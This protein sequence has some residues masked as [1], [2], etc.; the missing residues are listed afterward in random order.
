[1][2]QA[3]PQVPKIAEKQNIN[4]DHKTEN[5]GNQLEE[6]AEDSKGESEI[7]S[8]GSNDEIE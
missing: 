2:H 8:E 5:F 4:I 1:V 7:R 6:I 3:S